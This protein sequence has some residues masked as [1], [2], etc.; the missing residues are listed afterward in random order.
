MKLFKVLGFVLLIA[1]GSTMLYARRYVFKEADNTWTGA[2]TFSGGIS[3]GGTD[4]ENA[5]VLT[6]AVNLFDNFNDWRGNGNYNAI[7]MLGN[8][9]GVGLGS[10]PYISFKPQGGGSGAGF[11]VGDD[12]HMRIWATADPFTGIQILTGAAAGAGTRDLLVEDGD[13]AVEEGQAIQLEGVAGDTGINRDADLSEMNTTIDGTIGT[14]LGANHW[15]PPGCPTDLNEVPFGG[16]CTQV[17]T[18]KLRYRGALE[19]IP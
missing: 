8:D 9:E 5:A 15:R 19:A 4:L 16:I 14:R 18:G 2:Q 11:S 12:G 3:A 1:F 10:S 17:S 6:G 7:R 13:L